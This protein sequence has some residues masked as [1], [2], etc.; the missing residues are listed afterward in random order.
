M[1][2][3][4]ESGDFAFLSHPLMPNFQTGRRGVSN[5]IVEVIE[6]Q[7]N[8]RDGT[9]TYKLLD[10]GWLSGKILSRIAPAGTPAFT[11]A[12]S[13]QRARYAFLA[14]NTT[15]A[16]SDGTPGKTIF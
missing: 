3:T 8:Y 5:Q 16:Y 12:T 10:S 13:S 14:A 1:T 15:Q 4:V 7:P 6:K 11:T 9:M 2:L